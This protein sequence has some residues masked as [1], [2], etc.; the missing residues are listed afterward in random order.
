MD[1]LTKRCKCS[2]RQW[3]KCPHPWH[4]GFQWKKVEYRHSLHKVY[5]LPPE[6]VMT[7]SEAL[8]KRDEIRSKIRAGTF[9][10]SSVP[11]LP[12]G[13]KSTLNDVLDSYLRDFV[14]TQT[15]RPR[16]LETMELHV[17]QIR[18]S[19]V[20]AGG[21]KVLLGSKPIDEITRADIEEAR[22]SWRSH[23][24]GAKQGEAGAN[25]LLVRI[26]HM[27][28]W[29]VERGYTDSNPAKL[30]KLNRQAETSR[31][32]RLDPGEYEKLIEAAVGDTHVRDM[33]IAACETGCRSGELLSLQWRQVRMHDQSILLM[34]VKTKTNTTRVIPMTSRLKAVLEF[35]RLDPAGEEFGPDAYVFGNEVGERV[36][37]FA[38]NKDWRKVRTAAG[39]GPD[40]HFH[41]L[42]REFLSSLLEAGVPIHDV[43]AFAGHTSLVTTERYLKSTVERLRGAVDLLEASRRRTSVAHEPE[44]PPQAGPLVDGAALPQAPQVDARRYG[45]N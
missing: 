8:A 29:A 30:V 32:R 38:F 19:E 2:S 21:H 15:R 45:V 39:I 10:D 37:R 4:H 23:K 34:A 18:R 35:R 28:G 12:S 25:R 9:R 16:G 14:R 1:G 13:T 6:Y 26:K 24:P 33:L 7:K 5:D 3:T 43:S 40:L 36:C 41:D 44:E 17:K 11:G 42:R 22:A 20:T 31:E 27:F